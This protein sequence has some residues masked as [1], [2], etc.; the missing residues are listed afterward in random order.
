M[1]K[2]RNFVA[3]KSIGIKDMSQKE[4][5][6]KAVLFDMDGV[7]FNS[8][9][10]H[11]EAWHKDSISVAK[12]PICMKVVPEPEQSTLSASVNWAGKPLRTK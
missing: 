11:A 2:K 3:Q 1:Q 5:H 7:L 12:K 10:Y 4:I 8:M 6:L 9:P